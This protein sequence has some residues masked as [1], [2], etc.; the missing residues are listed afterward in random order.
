[1][2]NNQTQEILV[3]ILVRLTALERILQ[4]NKIIDKESYIKELEAVS[5][6]MM[7]VVLKTP[8]NQN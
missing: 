4:D 5:A 8:L 2:E 7:Q 1:M 3:T 6:E